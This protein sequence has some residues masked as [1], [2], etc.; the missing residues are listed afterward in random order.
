MDLEKLDV[1]FLALRILLERVLQDFLGLR[2]AAIGEIDLGFGDRIDLVRVDAAETF[3]AEVG[4]ERVL[5]GVNH[6]SA[7][8]AEHR[9]G[10]DVRAADDA[11]FELDG[12]A[13]ARRDQRR[14]SCERREGA[15]TD[16]PA[17][18]AAEEIVV[19]RR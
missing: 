12:A 1:D 9:V 16:D 10:L 5:A 11:V 18:R 3:A 19:P 7:R 8:R 4:G 15:S 13:A 17:G 2:V 6:T 14:D